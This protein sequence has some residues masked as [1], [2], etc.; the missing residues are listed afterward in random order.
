MVLSATTFSTAAL[1]AGRHTITARYAGDANNAASTSPAMTLRI[2]RAAT[3]AA[4]SVT[5]RKPKDGEPVR[6]EARFT[7]VAP[8]SAKPNGKVV[9]RAGGGKVGKFKLKNGKMKIRLPGLKSGKHEIKAVFRRT[10]NWKKSR[11]EKTV[12]VKKP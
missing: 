5:P 1:P 4:I 3:K 7:A 11:A 10:G 12:T 6:V 2:R 8:S 9:V